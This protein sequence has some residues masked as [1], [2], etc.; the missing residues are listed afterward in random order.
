M[1]S[2]PR[3]Y[4]VVTHRD[5]TSGKPVSL[6]VR[7]VED[8]ELGPTFVALSDFLFES[9]SP[10][11]D[12]AL[13]DLKKRYENTRK[14]HLSLYHIVSIEEVGRSNPG[15]DLSPERSNVIVLPGQPEA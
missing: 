3:S 8:S 6:R 11:I 12:P 2:K 15:L 4:Y 14:L 7:K 1:A 13:E 9:S 10:I 5:P